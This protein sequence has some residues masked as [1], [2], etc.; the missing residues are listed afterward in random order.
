VPEF[1]PSEIV[2]VFGVVLQ[3]PVRFVIV[4]FVEATCTYPLDGPES[5]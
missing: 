5:E 1:A 2:I 4:K 3:F